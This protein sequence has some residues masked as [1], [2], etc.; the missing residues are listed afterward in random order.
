MRYFTVFLLFIFFCF[1][2]EAQSVNWAND[3]APILYKHCV[4]CHHDGAIGSFSLMD[5]QSAFTNRDNILD[6]VSSRKMPPWKPDPNYRH[7][8]KENYLS[9]AQI[10]TI[11]Q[12]V[13]N[14][15]PA[16]DLSQAPPQP[17]FIPGSAVGIP[18]LTLQTPAYTMNA[19]E[20]E[21]RCFVLPTGI[22]QTT[23]LRGLEVIPGNHMAVHHVLIY[24]D[25]NG[26]GKVL[27]EQTPEPGY[28]SFGGPGFQGAKL[29]GSWVPGA[30]PDLLPPFM[31]IKLTAGADLI[32]QVHFPG[33]ATGLTDQST[34][35]L[36]Y[37]PTNQNI[38]QVSITPPL[39]HYPPSL[40]NGPLFIPANEEKT[41]TEQYTVQQN[42]SLIGIAPH[43]HLIGQSIECYGITPTNDTIKLIKIPSWDFHWQGNYNFQKIQK[44]PAGTKVY[45]H[46]RYNNTESN[47]NNPSSPPQNVLQGEATTDEM[48]LVYFIYTA[49]QPGD[50]NIILDS[51]LI[52]SNT[53]FLDKGADNIAQLISYPNPATSFTDIQFDLS[54]SDAIS[55]SVLNADGQVVRAIPSEGSL[56]TGQHTKRIDLTGLPAGNYSISL[57]NRQ[58]GV[59][60]ESLV[61]I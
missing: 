36:F 13:A 22:S 32:V 39:F 10:N 4:Q 25:V 58:G 11:E 44:L 19:T 24:E 16:G 56:P 20:D 43:M 7:Y 41:F 46:A 53:L 37:T 45:A 29:V 52:A 40:Q 42:G 57:K 47:P 61:K 31:G 18:D 28:V 14:N 27:D 38:R 8:A 2:A 35:N 33:A 21:Y 1:K 15:A 54:T 49:Y 12:W 5:Y 48:M 50:E 26:Q 34:L 30:R 17:T 23:Y 6:A 55:I 51:T 3:I 59:L 9:T 60:A